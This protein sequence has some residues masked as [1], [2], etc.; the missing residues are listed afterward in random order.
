MSDQS[1]REA[2]RLLREDL[3]RSY[4]DRAQY[5]MMS[6]TIDRLDSMLNL[7]RPDDDEQFCPKCFEGVDAANHN[8]CVDP[9]PPVQVEV[10]VPQVAVI[11]GY[12]VLRER[13]GVAL[14]ILHSDVH[15][16]LRAILPL[17]G[18][19]PLLDRD[20]VASAVVEAASEFAGSSGSADACIGAVK[21][22]VDTIMELARPMPTSEVVL[23][24]LSTTLFHCSD[25]EE[26]GLSAK[27]A[28]A[29]T[30]RI[31]ALLNG[32]GS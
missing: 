32:A 27:H 21:P 8:E 22:A 26:F 20:E 4:P 7:H 31:M 5:D 18:P 1:L 12:E 3:A 15:A 28:T 30:D 29:V 10:E 13:W 23:A 16:L 2:V 17:L 6:T 9:R 11:R 24:M 19:R 14:P 25:H